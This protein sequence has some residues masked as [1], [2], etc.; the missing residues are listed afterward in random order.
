MPFLQ[1]YDPFGNAVISTLVA[2]LPIILLLGLLGIFNVPAQWSALA[3]LGGALLVAIFG[4]GMPAQ[5]ALTTAVYGAANGLL[6][7]GWIVLAAVFLYNL[8]VENGSFEVLKNL[9]SRLSS[10]KRILVLLVAFNFG[11][12]FE[13]AAGFGTPVAICAALLIGLDFP[14]LYAAGLSLIANTAPVAFGA[15][16]TPILTLGSVTKLDPFIL[17]Q[18]AGRQLPLVS[19]IIPFWIIVVMCGWKGLR[20]VLPH[21]IVSG[22]SFAVIQFLWSNFVGPELVDIT[23]GVGSMIITAIFAFYVKP[24]DT[25]DFSEKQRTLLGGKGSGGNGSNSPPVIDTP[26]E[27]APSLG[28]LQPASAA[29]AKYTNAQIARAALPWLL[30]TLFVFLWGVPQVKGLLDGGVAGFNAR[31]S[32][33]RAAISLS[34]KVKPN[35]I[36]DPQIVVPGLDHLVFRDAPVAAKVDASKINDPAYQKSKAEAA[37]YSLNWLSATGTGILFAAILTILLLRI[38]LGMVGRVILLTLNR[39]K[40]PLL[41]ITCMLALGYVTRYGGT[42]ATLGLAFTHTGAIYPF[43]AAFLGW[44]GVALTG[45]DTSSNALFGSLQVITA[46][47]LGLNPILIATANSTGGV[48][49]KMVDAQSITVSTAATRQ[50]GQEGR[51]LRFV[52]V[53]SL[54]LATIMGVIVLLQAYVFTWVIPS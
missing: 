54:L 27:V 35:P 38:P 9:V 16:A 20:G 28:E 26:G 21:V 31:V 11:A 17:G 14:P 32:N 42:D 2:A 39:M 23:A 49:G 30:L 12:F 1:V 47:Q 46:K 51:I 41:T 48:M 44:L 36:T 5:T 37:V 8:T 43:F 22:L 10:D 6:P 53:H 18:M 29:A 7:I 4:F 40:Y 15:I 34:A 52:L 24:R 50:V 3:G 13:G 45:S 19:L 25:W 33:P